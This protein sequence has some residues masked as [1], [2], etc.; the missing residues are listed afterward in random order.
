[1][2]LLDTNVLSELAR[3]APDEG[4]LR[5]LAGAERIHVSVIVFH[6]IAYGAAIVTDPEQRRRI[7]AFRSKLFE[8][9]GK[10]SIPVDTD[11]AVLAAMKRADCRRRGRA[12]TFADS[13][14]AATAQHRGLVLVTRNTRDFEGLGVDL[15]DP[16]AP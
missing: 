14:I 15:L 7:E 1:M 8:R 4:V 5:F 2:Y 11:I 6:E 9:F 3:R 16:F 12:L 13:L 10:T